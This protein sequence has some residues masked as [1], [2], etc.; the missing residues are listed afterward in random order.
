MILDA[1]KQV[2]LGTNLTRDEARLVMNQIMDGKATPAQIAGLLVALV[3]KGETAEEVTGFVE[4][5]RSHAV[6]I[7]IDD[8]NA[9]DGC[10]T[11]GDNKHS[12]NIST[13]AAVVASAAGV[14]IAKH[15]NRSVSSKCGSADLLEATGGNIDPGPEK[16]TEMINTVGFG[17]LF[18]PRFHPAMK[19]AA[20]PRRELGLRTVFNLLGP[21]TNPASVRRQVI[22]VYD[23]SV[24][25][26]MIEVLQA[27]GSEHVI[28]AHSRDGF[29]EFSISAPTDYLELKDGRITDHFVTP[30]ELGFHSGQTNAV[31][32]GDADA[33]LAILIDV[34]DGKQGPCRD[35]VVINAG[36]MIYVGGLADSIRH[37]VVIAG[38]TIDTGKA[39]K[40]L[41]DWITTGSAE[42]S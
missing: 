6:K 33:N 15:G 40:K 13:A 27:T 30:D 12:F 23:K 29:D 1:I 11:G 16:V 24:M 9:V 5:M 31:T 37:G 18:A 36:A 21:M 34:I 22:G 38:E 7:G 39:K 8:K 41:N 4:S 26:L 10:G 32:G 20:V 28:V 19:H 35:A 17:F 2:I 42:K 14:T 25:R 3:K